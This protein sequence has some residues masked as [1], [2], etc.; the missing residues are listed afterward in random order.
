VLWLAGRE[1]ECWRDEAAR[2]PVW[3]ITVPPAADASGLLQAAEPEISLLKIQ[4][5]GLRNEG[6]PLG[7]VDTQ[8]WAYAAWQWLL[9]QQREATMGFA[10]PESASNPPTSSSS[11]T[12]RLSPLTPGQGVSTSPCAK[13]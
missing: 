3:A 9:I 7:D 5:C 12:A 4:S 11:A 6:V 2:A 10:W 1:V 8:L 13:R